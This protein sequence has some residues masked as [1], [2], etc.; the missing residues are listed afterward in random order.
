MMMDTVSVI[1][2]REQGKD[3]RD[4]PIVLMSYLRPRVGSGVESME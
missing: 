2:N 1:M 3:A 4:E